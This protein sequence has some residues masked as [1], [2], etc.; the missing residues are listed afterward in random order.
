MIEPSNIDRVLS[1]EGWE[2]LL[3]VLAIMIF[4]GLAN[5][6][7]KFQGQPRDTSWEDESQPAP[8]PSRP[9]QSS[10][11]DELRRMLEEEK[12]K[13]VAPPLLAPTMYKPA[14]LRPSAT[15]HHQEE[16]PSSP[17]LAHLTQSA[18][19]LERAST[20]HERVAAHFHLVDERTDLHRP[21]I[22]VAH[23]RKRSAEA[24][25]AVAL[26]RKPASARQ[27]II[28]SLILGPPKALEV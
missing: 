20:L 22:P 21:A 19:A 25:A 2:S 6:V 26:L 28:V 1:A 7:K 9:A 27:A 14:T 3:I 5:L 16:G 8:S 10:W 4:S 11:E 17:S 13:H 23:I 24:E 12:P 18:T 15:V